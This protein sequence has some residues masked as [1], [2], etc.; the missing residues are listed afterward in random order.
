MNHARALTGSETACLPGVGWWLLLALVVAVNIMLGWLA[1]AAVLAFFLIQRARPFDF[2]AAF[3]IVMGGAMFVNYGAGRLTAELG[4]VTAGSLFMVLCYTLQRAPDV[5][6]VPATPLTLPL[7]LYAVLSLLNFQRGLMLGNSPRYAGLEL[8][9]PLALASALLVATVRFDRR[10]IATTMV[11]LFV[12]GMANLAVSMWAFTIAHVRTGGIA[13]T[14]IDGMIA[15][16]AIPFVLREPVAQ[17]RWIYLAALTPMLVHQFLSFT[18]GL[19]LA[20]IGVVI[21]HVVVYVGRGPGAKAR[22]QRVAEMFAVLLAVGIVGIAVVATA[23]GMTTDLGQMAASRFASS[24]SVK[25]TPETM[26]NVI[27]IAE[28]LTALGHIARSPIVGHGLGFSYVFRSPVGFGLDEHWYV[29]NDYLLVW[30]KQGIIGLALLVWILIASF[31]T[32]W[33]LRNHPDL[34]L[35][36]WGL[37][38]AAVSLHFVIY[39]S[40]NFPFGSVNAVFLAALAWGGAMA[41]AATD[42]TIL[43][44]RRGGTT[45]EESRA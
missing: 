39:S 2:L 1:A 9:P 42:V 23:L 30:L 32:G 35:G 3:M 6:R 20:L 33:R 10:T 22:W 38:A 11:V 36:S 14:G 40:T 7:I 37:G 43:R 24:G 17:R 25:M 15:A 8:I 41:I 28:Y 31:R 19:W 45:A 26:S 12:L 29:H 4:M 34:Y 18:R 21:F 27:R 16:L 13:F 5:V 44:W